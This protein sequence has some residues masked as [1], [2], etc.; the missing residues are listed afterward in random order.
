M[1]LAAFLYDMRWVLCFHLSYQRPKGFL[2]NDFFNGRYQ[3]Q[4]TDD[5]CRLLQGIL[6]NCYHICTREVGDR[7]G[8]A[9]RTST[10]LCFSIHTRLL[11]PTKL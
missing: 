3:I 8:K 2:Q 10:T 5:R 6:L 4:I 9:R 11:F 1:N 7:G